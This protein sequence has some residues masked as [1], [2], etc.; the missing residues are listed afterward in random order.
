MRIPLFSTIVVL[1][2]LIFLGG[3][4]LT[5]LTFRKATQLENENKTYRRQLD[6]LLQAKPTPTLENLNL[7]HAD[8]T[9]LKEKLNRLH[10]QLDSAPKSWR[11]TDLTPP[12]LL[13]NLKEF[14]DTF[15]NA[16]RARENPILVD[17]QESFGF[18]VYTRSG[19][20]PAKAH[21]ATIA[22]QYQIIA[23]LLKQLYAAKPHRILS[24]KREKVDQRFLANED[25]HINEDF[26][27]PPPYLSAREREGIRTLAFEI[28]FTGYTQS[29]RH[30]LNQIAAKKNLT[31]TPIFVRSVTVRPI[32]SSQAP[33][34]Q[35][36]HDQ[37][38][39]LLHSITEEEDK[40]S[41]EEPI[42]T[43]SHSRFSVVIECIQAVP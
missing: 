13:F 30:F 12:Q 31:A 9:R 3:T 36:P 42:I 39:A 20:P 19:E 43:A 41:I 7:A 25:T 5:Y 23:H 11:D 24:V 10:Q 40:V 38:D 37:L 14:A 29:L 33:L 26:F 8:I 6:A 21:V 16:A 4:S 22:R 35:S 17:E 32:L 18:A 28:T 2:G 34:P 1:F 15:R 27:T